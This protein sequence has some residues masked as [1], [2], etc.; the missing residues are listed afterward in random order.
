MNVLV[1]YSTFDVVRLRR[2]MMENVDR[3][4]TRQAMNSPGG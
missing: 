2:Q 3:I 1:G 4:L